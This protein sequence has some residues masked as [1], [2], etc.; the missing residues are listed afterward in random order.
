[1]KDVDCAKMPEIGDVIVGVVL[2]EFDSLIDCCEL[3]FDS[4]HIYTFN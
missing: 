1:M 2:S 3:T 4:S